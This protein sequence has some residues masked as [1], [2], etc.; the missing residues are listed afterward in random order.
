[1][2]AEER[3]RDRAFS[4]SMTEMMKMMTQYMAQ[5]LAAFFPPFPMGT[6]MGTQQPGPSQQVPPYPLGYLPMP[7]VHGPLVSGP[8][9]VITPASHG[10]ASPHEEEDE[11]AVFGCY[12][13]VTLPLLSIPP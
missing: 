10:S 12:I 11:S 2:E 5:Q 8:P 4:T 13:V 7:Y 1:M 3:E 6:H 9:P